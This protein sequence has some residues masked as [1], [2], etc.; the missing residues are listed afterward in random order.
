MTK[1]E[2]II[3]KITGGGSY[4]GLILGTITQDT[5]LMLSAISYCVGIILGVITIYIKLEEH[6]K[7]R[8]NEN[9][10]NFKGY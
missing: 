5:T 8:R 6:C 2:I 10:T 4:L 1:Q 7:K 3:T 9:S